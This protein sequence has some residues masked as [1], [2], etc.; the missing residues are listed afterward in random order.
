[1][2]MNAL[3][4]GDHDLAIERL[5]QAVE[6]GWRGYYVHINDP[7]WAVLADDPRFVKLMSEV[8]ADVDRQAAEIDRIDAEED[9]IAILDA[10]RAERRA[11]QD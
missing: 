8:K 5:G 7:R 4:G 11:G 6:A 9:F 10:M 1:M 3:L 2:A